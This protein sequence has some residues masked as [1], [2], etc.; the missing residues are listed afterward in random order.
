MKIAPPARRSSSRQTP[1]GLEISIP[2][3]RNIFILLFLAAWLVGWG[4]GEVSAARELLFGRADTPVLFLG[5]WLIAWTLGGGV[6][7][8][9]WLWTLK[10]REMVIL[11]PDTIV[12]KSDLWGLG[13]SKEYDLQHT[14][15]LRVA[16]ISWNPHDWGAAMQFWGI[17][18]GPIAFDY[19]SQTVR[20][21]SGLDEAE[22]REIVKELRSRHAFP[23]MAV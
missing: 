7:L 2:A 9:T 10:G 5:G 15:N 3:K 18:G 17:G 1:E 8:Y 11:R 20:I 13:R 21:G 12:S 14:K 23:E 16:P 22:A 4:V 19:G 6:A